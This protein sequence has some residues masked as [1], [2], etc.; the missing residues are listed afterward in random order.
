MEKR[1]LRTSSPPFFF[2]VFFFLLWF[3]ITFSLPH[4]TLFP[5]MLCSLHLSWIFVSLSSLFVCLWLA[6]IFIIGYFLFEDLVLSFFLWARASHMHDFTTLDCIV[7]QVGK[8]Y[9]MVGGSPLPRH[10]LCV[11]ESWI[12]ATHSGA[13][14]RPYQV[15]ILSNLCLLLLVRFHF[16]YTCS[17]LKVP[18]WGF[19]HFPFLVFRYQRIRVKIKFLLPCSASTFFK[20]GLMVYSKQLLVYM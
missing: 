5:L 4:P 8:R 3:K 13:S 14:L 6:L 2:P 19:L 9:H 20:L 1:E 12:W 15:N 11:V 10:F 7:M 16:L 17:Y 18:F